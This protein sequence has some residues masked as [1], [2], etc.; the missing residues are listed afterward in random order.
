MNPTLV[1]DQRTVPTSSLPTTTGT[2]RPRRRRIV[3]AL[4]LMGSVGLV[5]SGVWWQRTVTTNPLEFTG[6]ADNVFRPA[7]DKSGIV[8]VRNRV[9]AE[10][11]VDHVPGGGFSAFMDLHNRS[12]H[13]VRIEAFAPTSY[14]YWGLHHVVVA[15]D[16]NDHFPKGDPSRFVPFTLP[17]GESRRV[18][19]DFRFADCGPNASFE[20]GYSTI[21]SLPV[22]YRLF[23]FSRTVHV[24]FADAALTSQT[25]VGECAQPVRA[26]R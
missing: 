23:G 12:G 11:T 17:A 10:A 3:A 16:D 18:R 20:R 6:A 19:A 24:A 8:D 4:A 7:G 2:R 13:D 15:E 26:D 14:H 25:L 1:T 9:G 21:G 5:V 22:R